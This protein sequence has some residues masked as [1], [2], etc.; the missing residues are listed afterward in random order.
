VSLAEYQLRRKTKTEDGIVHFTKPRFLIPAVEARDAYP[1]FFAVMSKRK[2]NEKDRSSVV[3]YFIQTKA[4]GPWKATATTWAL[5]EP[6]EKPSASEPSP[7]PSSDENGETVVSVRPKRLPGMRRG[8]SGTVQLSATAASDRAVCDGFADYLSF[9]PPHGRPADDR[10]TEGA[11]SSDL[12]ELHNGWANKDLERSFSYNV[13]GTD[14]PVF[15]LVTGSSLV[16]CTFVRE[17]H[18]SGVGSNGTV[19]F[20]KGSDTDALLGGGARNWRKVDE[21]SS[22]TALIE[23]PARKSSPA[24]VLA[25]DCYDPQLLSATG[26]A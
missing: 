26:V 21:L 22:M 18:V 14:L 6:I 13:V 8:P 11:F 12:V 15:R 24:T 17:H 5:T 1:R 25:C 3:F 19:R 20:D 10:F 9:E 23:V 7:A 4:D 2:G 16:A